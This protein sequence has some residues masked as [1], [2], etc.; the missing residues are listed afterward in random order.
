MI[1]FTNEDGLRDY[2]RAATPAPRRSGPRWLLVV[3]LLGS[4]AALACQRAPLVVFVVPNPL[5]HY[6]GAWVDDDQVCVGEPA[7]VYIVRRCL[8]MAAI[9]AFILSGRVAD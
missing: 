9:R 1:P 7:P 2:R 8:S 5:T 3:L 6:I 4:L